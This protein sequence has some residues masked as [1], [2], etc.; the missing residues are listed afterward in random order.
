MV[1]ARLRAEAEQQVPVSMAVV[2]GEAL[3]E[4]G[5]FT[6]SDLDSRVA[7]LQIGDLNGTPTVFLRGVGGGGR[8]VGF[9]PRTGFYIDG[10]FMNQPPLADA[11]LLD[12]DRV[13]VLRGPQ[14]SL[15]GQN[16]DSGAISLVTKE[17]GENLSVQAVL[18]V[19]DRGE[20]RIGLAQD[21]PIIAKRLLLRLSGN[22]AKGD[23][24]VTNRFDGKK[25]D[26]FNEAGARARLQWRIATGLNVDFAADVASHRDDFPTGEALSSSSGQGPDANPGAYSVALNT[27]QADNMRN[28]GLSATVNWDGSFGKLTSISAWRESQRHWVVDL[29]YSPLDAWKVDNVDHYQRWSQELRLTGHSQRLPLTWLAGVYAFRQI[30]DSDRA[31]P[32]GPRIG[33]FI[34]QVSPGDN[35]VVTP[36]LDTRSAAVFGS[37]GYALQ[38]GLRLDAGL[39]LVGVQLR[40]DYSQLSTGGLRAIGNQ[41]I[42]G[43]ENRVSESSALPDVAL[44]WDLNPALTAYARYAMG[45]KSGGFDADTLTSNRTV[46][47]EFSE[48][49]V[50]SYELGLKSQWLQRR[51][52]A[53]LALFV[54]DY[55]DY[56]VSQFRP[57]GVGTITV[58]VVSNAGKVRSYGPELELLA[59]P[60][61]GLTLRSSTAWVHAEY[62]E[63]KNGGGNG[64]DFSGH[65]AEYAPRWTSNNAIEYRRGVDWGWVGSLQ[66][67]LS[68]SWRSRFYTQPSNLPIFLADTRNLL[69]ARLG[70]QDRSSRFELSVYGDNL[71]DDR[72]LETLNRGTLGTRFGRYGAPRSFGLQLQL[73]TG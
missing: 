36:R 70:L 55:D 40:L 23:G 37:V 62:V 1:T 33:L 45:S 64:I 7:N 58:P 61:R 44:S 53:N 38:P 68:Y 27:P 57:T 49:T 63:F 14:G 46:P 29:D 51:L 48:E 47:G 73:H 3:A 9:E 11:L 6:L 42:L 56:Q 31:V 26:A 17:P 8:Q 71:L 13:E 60:L 67:A 72:Y 12:L 21:M 59:R 20:Q 4:E 25:P 15:F 54:A 69:G 16:T 66:G 65:R 10:V 50:N 39:R 30:S 19:D 43:Y 5:R 34:P 32:A 18:R 22:L 28:S 41:T 2:S 24:F 52:R 35:L